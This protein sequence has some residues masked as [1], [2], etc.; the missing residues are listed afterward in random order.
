MPELRPRLMDLGR[1]TMLVQ[2][3][4]AQLLVT[5]AHS[6]AVG[7]KNADVDWAAVTELNGQASHTL[8][9]TLEPDEADFRKSIE[10][11]EHSLAL[12]PGQPLVLKELTTLY[13]FAERWEDAVVAWRRY[14]K[15]ESE[16]AEGY[17]KLGDALKKLQRM[18]E[19]VEAYNRALELAPDSDDIRA[20]R[21]E[22]I[23]P[24]PSKLEHPRP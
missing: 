11:L 3:F 17:K 1:L 22:A 20:A 23:K 2:D 6:G 19:A 7:V 10:L 14:L 8:W 12:A 15:I 18:R 5:V 9:R 13:A 24:P 16:D 21:A 4:P